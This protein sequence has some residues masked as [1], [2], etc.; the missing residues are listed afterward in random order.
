MKCHFRIAAV[1]LFSL[2]AVAP[3]TF[4][5]TND[6]TQPSRMIQNHNVAPIDVMESRL[7][8]QQM[9]IDESADYDEPF[10]DNPPIGI[11]GRLIEPILQNPIRAALDND[12]NGSACIDSD[13]VGAWSGLHRSANAIAP[14]FGTAPNELPNRA[15]LSLLGIDESPVRRINENAPQPLALKV[16]CLKP[17]YGAPCSNRCIAKGIGCAPMFKHPY[18]S[19]VGWGKLFACNTLVV[20]HMCSFHYPNG[21]DCFVAFPSLIPTLCSYSGDG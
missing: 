3:R 12:D 9:C 6:G 14:I 2:F 8:S 19:D 18:K 16:F 7:E 4:A 10:T 5:S 11:A 17:E 15:I 1:I 13:Y 21:D 20:G